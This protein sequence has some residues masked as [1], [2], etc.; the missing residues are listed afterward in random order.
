MNSI[1]SY[2][3]RGNYGD[4]K[5]R[6]NCSG[7]IIREMLEHYQPHVFVDP[8]VGGNT[9]ADVAKEMQENGAQ[10]E[11][12]GFDLHSGFNI[13]KDSLSEHIGGARADY[14]FAHPAYFKMVEYS[15]NMWGRAHPDDLSRCATYQE[16][17]E[18]MVVAMQNIY[19]A[20]RANGNFSILI[21]DYKKNN[22]YISIQ[23][24][25]LQLAP[26]KLDGIIIKTQHNCVS[27]NR[28]YSGKSLIRI[29]HEYL[30]NFR[31]DSVMFGLLDASLNVSRKLQSLAKANWCATIRT[32]LCKI[33]GKGSLREIYDAIERGASALIKNRPNWQARVRATLQAHFQ[34][35]ERGVWAI[36][37]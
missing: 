10:L 18:K 22:E 27:D 11:F 33:G 32:A 34:N 20:V 2:P 12:H 31:K 36:Q 28:N 9:S 23:S 17:L 13:L 29:T 37:N 3:N 6:G 26:G 8:M 7:F 30:L 5:Y 15:G 19:E 14:V 25:L 1:V 24:D 35:L 16:Y 21:G 4:S